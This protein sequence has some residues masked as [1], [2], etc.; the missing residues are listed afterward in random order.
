MTTQI[1]VGVGLLGQAM[2]TSRFLVQ[3]IASERQGRSVIPMAFW[4][5]SIC[6]GAILLAYAIWRQDPV[7]I[8]GQLFGVV[9]YSRNIILIGRGR[10]RDEG[11][12]Q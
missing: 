9:V 7:F 6:G 3:W 5:L 11:P 8:I 2:F 10:L 1:W 4:W 12:K